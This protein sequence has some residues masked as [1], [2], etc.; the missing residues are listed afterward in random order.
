MIQKKNLSSLKCPYCGSPVYLRDASD[1]YHKDLPGRKLYV[2]SRYPQCDAYSRADPVTLD[3]LSTL[4]N[5]KLRALRRQTHEC[6][7]RIYEKNIMS[8]REAYKWLSQIIQAPCNEAH[9]GRLN[10]YYCLEVIKKSNQLVESW[11]KVHDSK[12]ER[13]KNETNGKSAENS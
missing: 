8:K 2:C 5:G 3:M 12:A 11:E 1:I 6:F 9:I 4:A 7:N 13:R 10:E